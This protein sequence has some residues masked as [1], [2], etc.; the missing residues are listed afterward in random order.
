MS[1]ISCHK[2]IVCLLTCFFFSQGR[3][4]AHDFD[5]RVH[6][7]YKTTLSPDALVKRLKRSAE[8]FGWKYSTHQYSVELSDSN[9]NIKKA[10]IEKIVVFVFPQEDSSKVRT[11]IYFRVLHDSTT[12]LDFIVY[13]TVYTGKRFWAWNIHNPF[14]LFDF[15]IKWESEPK[16]TPFTKEQLSA[17]FKML[18]S[19]EKPD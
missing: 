9:N 7:H 3:L 17:I 5:G 10:Y 4:D 15:R 2:L 11:R 8:K 1:Q 6:I 14:G 12:T 19:I 16:D 13:K 18:K